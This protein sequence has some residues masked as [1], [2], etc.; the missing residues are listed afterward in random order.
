MNKRNP[1]LTFLLAFIFGAPSILLW[2]GRFRTALAFFLGFNVAVLLPIALFRV[3]ID[4]SLMSLPVPTSNSAS[5]AVVFFLVT[6]GA[7]FLAFRVYRLEAR[8]VWYAN[9][10]VAF[11][12]FGLLSMLL[13]LGFRTFVLQPFSIP[14]SSM[15]PSLRKGDIIL[16]S[17]FAY[18]YSRHSFPFSAA[19]IEKRV[20]IAEPNRGD[21]AVFKNRDGVDYVKRIVGLPGESVSVR[22]GVVHIDGE[23][24]RMEAME[25]P[26]GARYC[27]NRLA[28]CTT[29]LETLPGSLPHVVIDIAKG[30]AA[31]DTREFLVP[32]GHYFMMGDDRDNSN[33]SRFGLGFIPYEN[34]IGRVW[35][36]I[37]NT[38]SI[39]YDGRPAL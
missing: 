26:E 34:L 38:E 33:D 17:K 21:I 9:W 19:P 6:L 31:D 10:K 15:E 32:A 8:P 14:A 1:Y 23:P 36:V 22:G 39:A 18:G 5:G 4:T 3:G 20:F 7:L 29:Y 25:Y 37:Y 35:T 11:L 16:V 30:T 13:A 28:S 27:E 12:G 24:A 2:H